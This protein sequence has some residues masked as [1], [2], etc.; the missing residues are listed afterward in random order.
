MSEC[1]GIEYQENL[2][3]YLYKKRIPHPD[4]FS[5][6]FSAWYVNLGNRAQEKVPPTIKVARKQFMRA[7]EVGILYI[8]LTILILGSYNSPMD[9]P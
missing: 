1:I 9:S 4:D 5:I 8:L 2:L 7:L 3:N 6:F